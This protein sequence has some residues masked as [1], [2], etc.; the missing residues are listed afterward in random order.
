MNA[1]ATAYNSFPLY[2]FYE[3]IRDNPVQYRQLV[4]NELL[5]TEFVCPLESRKQA[6]WSQH[7]YFVYVLEGKKVWHTPHGS[8]DLTKNSC[9]F[10][11][12]GASII[13]QFFDTR[14][15]VLLF[16][17]SDEFICET[18]RPRAANLLKSPEKHA[19]IMHIEADAT[20]AAYMQ[21]MLPYF[22]TSPRPDQSLLELKFRELLLNVAGNRRNHEAISYFRSLLQEPSAVSLRNIMEDNFCYNLKLEEYAR[23]CKR[24]LSAF[25]RDF[26][27]IYGMPPG[28]WLLERR[29]AHAKLL[30]MNADM[31]VSEVAY[32]SGFENLSHFSRVFREQ[33]GMTPLILRQQTEL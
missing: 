16:F 20:L 5:M 3:S 27:K 19:P 21:S 28:K 33:Y 7:N 32:E 8:F 25:K 14:F 11:C 2:N 18:L 29:L 6:I 23:L 17:I 9:V 31:A 15:C 10:V 4:C 12:K 30:L 13:E 1:P 24:S 26:Q 22:S